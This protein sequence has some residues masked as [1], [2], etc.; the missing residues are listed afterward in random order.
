MLFRSAYLVSQGVAGSRITT[1]GLGSSAP[2]ASNDTEA[3]RSQNR[4]VEVAIT[5]NEEMLKKAQEGQ[6]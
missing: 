3:G 4:R 5:A 6:L 1:Q 2:V